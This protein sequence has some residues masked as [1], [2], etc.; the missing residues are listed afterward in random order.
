MT[1]DYVDKDEPL[2]DSTSGGIVLRPRGVLV[3]TAAA[4]VLLRARQATA[5]AWIRVVDEPAVVRTV[6]VTRQAPRAAKRLAFGTPRGARRF[7]GLIRAWLVDPETLDLLEVAAAQQDAVSYEK[8]QRAREGKNLPGRRRVAVLVGMVALVVA[9]AW[10]APSAFAGVLAATVFVG[11]VLLLPRD[12][13]TLGVAAALAVAAWFAGP[14]LADQIPQPP[15][16]AWWALLGVAVAAFAWLG[17][18]PNRPLVEMP[19]RTVPNEVPRI[20]APM[21][22][23][24]LCAL[25]N[26]KMK[27]PDQVRVLMAPHRDGQGVRVDLELPA[28]TTARFVVEN[29]EKF[30]GAARL[31]LGTVWPSVGRRHPDHLTCYF[32][33]QAM[34]DADQEPWPLAEARRIDIFD[35]HPAFTDQPGAWISTSLAYASWVIGA[36][37]RM[38]KTFLVRQ[39]C[40]MAGMDP[41]VK[42]IALDGKGTGDLAPIALYAHGYVRGA[43]VSNPE[44][45][46]K[47]RAILRWLLEELGRRADIIDSLPVE[48][49]P[50]SKVTSEL[51]DAH[52]ELDLG[53]V[54]VAV[55]ETQSFF[56]YGF[57]SEKDHKEIR[58]ELRDG[59]VELMKLGPALGIWVV[60]ATQLVRESTV[61][62][63]A[64]AVAVNRFAL[65]LE[66]GHEPNDRIL[67]T[68]SYSR[69]IDANMFDFGD[70]GI[71]ILKAEGVRSA[72]CRTVHGLDAVESR[73][74]AARIRAVRARIGM[75]TGDAADDGIEDAELVID[76]VEDVEL[77]LRRRGRDDAQHA[78]V[79]EWLQEERPQHYAELTVNEL[80]ASLRGRGVPIRQ[81][82]SSGSNRKGVRMSDL[83]KRPAPP[84]PDVPIGR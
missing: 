32:S 72:I 46:E 6:A 82:W 16:W 4:P 22:I 12:L 76:V 42:V 65:K 14:W 13:A 28:G 48:E 37:P 83:R 68:G 31:E 45:I 26:S 43:R 34:A 44:N 50:E 8:V 55:D 35:A 58:D 49:C 10:W 18:D 23:A 56:S 38:G 15:G 7:V 27:D 19:P 69:G 33:D 67:G 80:S 73:R 11:L 41:R 51:V 40:L 57:K 84:P 61:P 78:E 25:G 75:L 39:L 1:I 53:P 64:A 59:F 3:R 77:A 24:A 5:R 62:T 20:T 30:A 9:L 66:G 36:A 52:P 74:V 63:E 70:K 47:V 17:R 21:V 2:E 81:V 79:V 60:L 71:G 54:F 29:R